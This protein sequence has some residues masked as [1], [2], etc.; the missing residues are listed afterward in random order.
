L[1]PALGLEEGCNV[2][3]RAVTRQVIAWIWASQVH[4]IQKGIQGSIGGRLISHCSA[5]SAI[6]HV[7]NAAICIGV[8]L[9]PLH[10]RE[11]NGFASLNPSAKKLNPETG[12][13]AQHCATNCCIIVPFG[14]V[15]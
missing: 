9:Q 6:N 10:V 1:E 7:M 4:V 8:L 11:F 5:A 13:S 15:Q 14:G 2:V 3:N 12:L